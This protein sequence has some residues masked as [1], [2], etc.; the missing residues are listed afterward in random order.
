VLRAVEPDLV[1][2]ARTI[3]CTPCQPQVT[4]QLE[5]KR[6]N[7]FI[8]CRGCTRSVS[9]SHEG[10]R[11]PSGKIHI[12]TTVAAIPRSTNSP[13]NTN[14]NNAASDIVRLA[15]VRWCQTV[16]RYAGTAIEPVRLGCEDLRD[17]GA[18]HENLFHDASGRHIPPR[19]TE[20][21]NETSVVVRPSLQTATRGV[22]SNGRAATCNTPRSAF[23]SQSRCAAAARVQMRLA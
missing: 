21:P 5:R 3:R 15:D 13:P 18:S 19:L 11:I 8:T 10:Q 9:A 6:V 14:T 20:R 17:E 2:G 4:H 12:N 7:N 22:P 23:D 1:C 16:C